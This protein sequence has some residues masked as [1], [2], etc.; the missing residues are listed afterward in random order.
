[1]TRN[2]DV[3]T[4]DATVAGRMGTLGS[5]LSQSFNGTSGEGDTPDSDDH[6]FGDGAND[7][8]FS[9]FAVVNADTLAG[10]DT[11]SASGRGWENQWL[12]YIDDG[13]P[14]FILADEST[15]GT[16]KDTYNSAL[17]AGTWY[18]IA[19]VYDGSGAATGLT[20]YVMQRP[21]YPAQ[22]ARTPRWRPSPDTYHWSQPFGGWRSCDRVLRRQEGPCRPLSQ[23]AVRRR[24]MD[25][26]VL[27]NGFFDY[28]SRSKQ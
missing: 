11:Y 4:W 16:I 22:T 6:E 28:L 13:K 12:F 27:H 15:G 5:G 14:I 23:G 17:S 25:D 21:T 7:E 19:G 20:V 18:F 8:A 1:M 10:N 24:S 3:V 26:E 9:V 2:A